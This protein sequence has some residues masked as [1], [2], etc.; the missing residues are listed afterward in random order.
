MKKMNFLLPQ[1]FNPVIE[2]NPKKLV[3][4]LNSRPQD[5]RRMHEAQARVLSKFRGRFSKKGELGRIFLKGTQAEATWRREL[6]NLATCLCEANAAA[7]LDKER[8]TRVFV[9]RMNSALMR[10]RLELLPTQKGRYLLHLEM[11]KRFLIKEGRH[12]ITGSWPEYVFFLARLAESG[13]RDRLR[14]CPGCSKFLFATHSNKIFCSRICSQ[15]EAWQKQSKDPKRKK[16]MKT[17]MRARYWQEKAQD[18]HWKTAA[19]NM[20]KGG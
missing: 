8:L 4:I 20:K 3:G 19:K 13:L 14:R 5:F 7:R 18:R 12:T 9:D 15:R 1:L 17:Y 11:H 16:Y 2:M 10:F 6:I